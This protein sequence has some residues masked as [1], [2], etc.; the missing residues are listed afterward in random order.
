M[1]NEQRAERFAWRTPGPNA[2]KESLLPPFAFTRTVAERNHARARRRFL[3][4]WYLNSQGDV[5]EVWAHEVHQVDPSD[6]EGIP[7]DSQRAAL[8]LPA[9]IPLT[10]SSLDPRLA[11][12]YVKRPRYTLES[13]STKPRT[14]RGKQQQ[15]MNMESTMEPRAECGKEQDANMEDD[16]ISPAND[17]II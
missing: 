5:V 12:Q 16:G 10:P 1:I 9:Y 3:R 15:D 13:G 4:A 7:A 2:G 8:K 14:D 11:V 6:G 17:D